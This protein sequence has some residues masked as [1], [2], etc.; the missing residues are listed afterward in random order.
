MDF[1]NVADILNNQ[2]PRRNIYIVSDCLPTQIYRETINVSDDEKAI[3][4]QRKNVSIFDSFLLERH[5]EATPYTFPPYSVVNINEMTPHKGTPADTEIRRTFLAIIFEE[6]ISGVI[7]G[8]NS[9]L[10]THLRNTP[11]PV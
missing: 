7:Y 1:A 2:H 8:D 4:I 5:R 11:I 3:L 9:Y 6:D 10:D